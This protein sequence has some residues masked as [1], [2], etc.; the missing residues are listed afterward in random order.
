MLVIYVILRGIIALYRLLVWG[1]TPDTDLTPPATVAVPIVLAFGY[2]A[3][4]L[5][6]NRRRRQQAL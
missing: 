5:F 3:Y 1:N 6:R 2:V 4:I